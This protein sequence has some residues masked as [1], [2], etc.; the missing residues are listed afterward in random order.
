MY[1]PNLPTDFSYREG[2]QRI[3]KPQSTE[4][5][6]VHCAA[7]GRQMYY[8]GQV[9][10][11]PEMVITVDFRNGD[12]SHRNDGG[13]VFYVHKRCF[14]GFQ[15]RFS[16]STVSP[17]SAAPVVDELAQKTFAPPAEDKLHIA[18]CNAVQSD[19]FTA[20]DILRQA[21]LDYQPTRL[22]RTEL[23]RVQQRGGSGEVSAIM[24]SPSAT[25]GPVE[26]SD[27]LR[28]A[29]RAFT[30]DPTSRACLSGDDL[31]HTVLGCPERKVTE[32]NGR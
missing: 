26:Q 31:V 27:T 1:D 2:E 23:I 21:L 17:A 15:I 22:T 13:K 18:I 6:P 28:C 12:Y 20:S 10:Y 8:A 5:R 25:A 19:Q 24:V 4:E 16:G 3:T 9:Q 32:D 30:L 7:C 14:E 29:C 11:E